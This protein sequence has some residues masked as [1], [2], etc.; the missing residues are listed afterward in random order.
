MDDSCAAKVA[1]QTL[2]CLFK[3]GFGFVTASATVSLACAKVNHVADD[4]FRFLT[5]SAIISSHCFKV[6]YVSNDSA[7]ESSRPYAFGA[8]N[9]KV[10]AA[11][12]CC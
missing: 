11:S 7:T 3:F 2:S 4:S 12:P 8:F 6:D 1:I 9:A 5:V 10:F